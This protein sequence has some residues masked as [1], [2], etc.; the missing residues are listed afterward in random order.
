MTISITPFNIMTLSI[1][2][3]SIRTLSIMTL[4]IMTHSITGLFVIH[5]TNDNQLYD[6]QH[7]RLICYTQH[8]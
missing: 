2:A 7:N 5:S 3:L 8:K 4:S 1:I 6:T